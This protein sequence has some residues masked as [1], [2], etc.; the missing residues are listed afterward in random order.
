M[1]M[2][3]G[4]IKSIAVQLLLQDGIGSATVAHLFKNNLDQIARELYSLTA[5]AIAETYN[6]PMRYAAAMYTALHNLEALAAHDSWCEKNG[7]RAV[8]LFDPEYPVLLKHIGAPP[9]VL[10]VRGVLPG[11]GLSSCALVG[12]RN[13]TAYGKRVVK[14]LVPGLVAGG[15]ATVSGGARGIDGWVH[16]ETIDAGGHT[17]VVMGCGLAHTYPAEHYTLFEDVVA[18]GG[19]LVSPFPPFMQP[20]PGTF[21][22]RNRIIAGLSAACV[23]VQA[24]AQSG[25]LITAAHAL[26]ENREVAAV[27]GPIDEPLSVGTNQLIAQGARV[28]ADVAS[29]LELC[30]QY[31]APMPAGAVVVLSAD[32]H[33]ILRVLDTALM[34]DELVSVSQKSRDVVQSA[35]F[36]LQLAGKCMQNHAGMWER[37]G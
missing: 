19:A 36:E 31:A 22:A 29:V 9:V 21:P 13:A 4:T 1:L 5:S 6:V 37:C 28:V 12:S 33:A 35:L 30:G 20:S 10:W 3:R 16:Q 2:D 18:S 17:T 32:A 34:F 24:A 14:M 26:E 15:V 11:A 25:A 8:T 27:P 23:V 7:V